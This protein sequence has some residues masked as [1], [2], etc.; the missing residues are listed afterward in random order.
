MSVLLLPLKALAATQSQFKAVAFEAFPIFDPPR[1]FR[2]RV[3]SLSNAWRTRQF[4]Y[5]WLRAIAGR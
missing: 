3:Q 1:S 2:E 5:Q 4:E